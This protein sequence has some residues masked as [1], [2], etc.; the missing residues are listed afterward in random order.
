M[1]QEELSI[2]GKTV[3]G[4]I[5]KDE[6]ETFEAPEGVH[7]VTFFSDE[8]TSLCPK[9]G[10]P[11]FYKI[12]IRYAPDE[13]CLESKS[14]K[15]YLQQFR[16]TGQFI[17]QLTDQI[18]NELFE[19]ID[20]IGIEVVTEMKPRGGIS[21]TAEAKRVKKSEEIV[22]RIFDMFGGGGNGTDHSDA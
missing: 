5:T 6:L 4:P 13:K 17:E 10:Q 18:A 19:V 15:L 8:M 9:T 16:N 21:I 3:S 1:P 14:L 2:L 11:D 20:P 12:S 7:E 22:G